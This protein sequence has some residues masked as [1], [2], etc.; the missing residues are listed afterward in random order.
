MAASRPSMRRITA[1]RVA[2]PPFLR[3][4][5]RGLVRR[6]RLLDRTRGDEHFAEIDVGFAPQDRSIGGFKD[7][8]RLP[9]RPSASTSA[10]KRARSG[11][12]RAPRALWRCLRRSRARDSVR[13]SPATRQAA[14]P[15]RR[16]VGPSTPRSWTGATSRPSPREQHTTVEVRPPP[17][18]HS[19]AS[20]SVRQASIPTERCPARVRA[21]GAATAPGRRGH[22]PC[23]TP[24]ASRR[25]LRRT[26]SRAPGLPIARCRRRPPTR[27]ARSPRRR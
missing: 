22:A 19:P 25:G 20:I 17:H 4:S 26:A 2:T 5:A 1:P 7:R 23:R 16:S 13:T 27:S 15:A 18:R 14:R 8:K 10:T 6:A 3:E 21:P 11:A 24:P 12:R 9:W